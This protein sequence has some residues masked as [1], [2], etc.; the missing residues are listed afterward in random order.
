MNFFDG[1]EAMDDITEELRGTKRRAEDPVK[2]FRCLKKGH[3][4][5]TETEESCSKENQTGANGKGKNGLYKQQ[6]NPPINATL[7][8]EG[9]IIIIKPLDLNARDLVNDPVE[10]TE[11][12]ED[13]VLHHM[14]KKMRVNKKKMIIVAELTNPT[15]EQIENVTEMRKLGPW[16]VLCRLPEDAS[17]KIGVV[18]PVHTNASIEKI[19][20]LTTTD[21]DVEIIK[22]ER[23]KKKPETVWI[24][25]PTLKITFQGNELPDHIYIGASYYKVRPYVNMPTQCYKCQRMGHTSHSCKARARCLICAGSHERKDCQSTTYRCANCDGEHTANSSQCPKMKMAQDIE[26][27]KAINGMTHVEARN[28]VMEVAEI[29]Q[30][31]NLTNVRPIETQR[32]PQ[33]KVTADVHRAMDEPSQRR[34]THIR[35]SDFVR[36][37]KTK[38]ETKA[39][40]TEPAEIET[41]VTRQTGTETET[42]PN[43]AETGENFYMKLKRCLMEVLH[44]NI[45][46]E[47]SQVQELMVE[48][49]IVNNF[50][51]TRDEAFGKKTTKESGEQQSVTVAAAM[52]ILP[53]RQHGRG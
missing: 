29:E 15:P 31:E 7:A 20:R 10:L 19:K 48:S 21:N 23:M 40:Q 12:I 32:E 43:E 34:G 2:E 35:Y 46:R 22:I 39:T 1:P 25:S 14:Q 38:M 24:D 44:S 45:R 52:H 11:A 36:Q 27:L 8:S 6:R 5:T 33:I 49:S 42:Q 53:H 3:T 41:P 26:R 47:T 13:S 30:P 17:S 50:A 28:E 16:N 18:S 37:K 9:T 4:S 51:I